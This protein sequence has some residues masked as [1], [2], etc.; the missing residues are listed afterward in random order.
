MEPILMSSVNSAPILIRNIE[1]FRKFIESL[2]AATRL[3]NGYLLDKVKV[4]CY[5]QKAI[6]SFTCII[7]LFNRGSN[8][9]RIWIDDG[10]R[11]GSPENI[12]LSTEERRYSL[13]RSGRELIVE[14]NNSYTPLHRIEMEEWINHRDIVFNQTDTSVCHT[15]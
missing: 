10:Q 11:T 1:V 5:G 15:L 7:I 2:K 8:A 12:L 3:A 9:G 6:H 14:A 4:T 13:G